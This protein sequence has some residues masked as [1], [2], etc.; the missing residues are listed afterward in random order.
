MTKGALLSPL[1][2]THHQQGFWA[3]PIQVDLQEY[4]GPD[5]FGLG[6]VV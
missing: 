1:H 4:R 6:V 2:F 5:V 3:V